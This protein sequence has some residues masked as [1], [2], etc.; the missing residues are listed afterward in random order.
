MRPLSPAVSGAIIAATFVAFLVMMKLELHP[1]DRTRGSNPWDEFSKVTPQQ[2]A[3]PWA[4]TQQRRA[5]YECILRNTRTNLD[6]QTLMA[7][8]YEFPDLGSGWFWRSW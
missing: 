5:I 4:D 8:C 6:E 7:A 2:Q 3:D 1:G